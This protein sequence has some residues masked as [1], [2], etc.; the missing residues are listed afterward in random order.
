MLLGERRRDF[1]LRLR[2]SVPPSD[3]WR[4]ERSDVG[5]PRRF[6]QFAQ[7][8]VKS[9]RNWAE[10]HCE[11]ALLVSVCG[12]ASSSRRGWRGRRR[13]APSRCGRARPCQGCWNKGSPNSKPRPGHGPSVLREASERARDRVT[14]VVPSS[15]KAPFDFARRSTLDRNRLLPRL[16]LLPGLLSCDHGY[17]APPATAEAD[18]LCPRSRL[19]LRRQPPSRFP[20]LGQLA[21]CVLG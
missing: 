17:Q 13:A 12:S 2:S 3:R 4:A 8:A 20:T 18:C 21:Q 16:T 5:Q 15:G 7:Q 11:G 6:L 1:K 10:R 9:W 14:L 19:R